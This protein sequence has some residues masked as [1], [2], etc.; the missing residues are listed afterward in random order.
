MTP[1]RMVGISEDIQEAQTL[2]ELKALWCFGQHEDNGYGDAQFV[3]EFKVAVSRLRKSEKEE[4]KMEKDELVAKLHEL[5]SQLGGL[6]IRPEA[7]PPVRTV[8]RGSRKYK[9]LSF[10]VGWSTKPQ[11]HA[12]AAILAAHAKVGE[13]LDNEAIVEMMEANVG[14]LGTRQGGRKIWNYYKGDWV[15]GLTAHGNIEPL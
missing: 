14:V 9:L 3:P 7:K 1:E 5:L 8:S 13:V 2:A 12:I 10:D 6:D 4:P 15:E 11:V